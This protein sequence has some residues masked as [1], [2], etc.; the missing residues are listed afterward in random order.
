M[1]CASR[2]YG[3]ADLCRGG[4]VMYAN[5]FA[6]TAVP[7]TLTT[8]STGP[9][10]CAGT[11]AVMV[12]ASTTWRFVAAPPPM[13]ID[14]ASAEVKPVPVIETFV[15]PAGGAEDGVTSVTLS[16]GRVYWNTAA[17]VAAPLVG[18]VT[19]TSSLIATC[20]LAG[21]KGVIAV[22]VVASTTLTLV[23]AT[24]PIFTVAPL[25]KFV[26]WMVTTVLPDVG[27]VAG[28]IEMTVGPGMA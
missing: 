1:T 3:F 9:T 22:M 18:F 21:P 23:A 12:T 19:T 26:P 15:P 8:T 13:V 28:V 24:P 14:E 25:W 17:S 10:A 11:V 2:L 6:V 27:P 16:A 7:P 4:A 5:P 20:S